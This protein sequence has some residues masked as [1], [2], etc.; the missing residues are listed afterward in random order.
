VVRVVHVKK[1]AHVRLVDARRRTASK[2][3]RRRRS[4]ICDTVPIQQ[5]LII[6][7]TGTSPNNNRPS[8]QT[9]ATRKHVGSLTSDSVKTATALSNGGRLIR[10]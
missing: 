10:P 3:V 7:V 1:L 4:R 5:S 9:S 2:S 8:L 6:L